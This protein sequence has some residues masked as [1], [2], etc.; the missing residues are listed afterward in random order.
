MSSFFD[1]MPSP[2]LTSSAPFAAD[3]Y[4]PFEATTAGLN[5]SVAEGFLTPGPRRMHE[6][7]ATSAVDNAGWNFQPKPTS[8]P[9]S[10]PVPTTEP[11]PLSRTATR[12][13]GNTAISPG[14]KRRRNFN[15]LGTKIDAWWSAVRSSFS[16]TPEEESHERERRRRTS[17]DTSGGAPL[18]SVA[19][20]TS[21]TFTRPAP[22]SRPSLRNVAS[23]QDLSR[24]ASTQ[25][26]TLTPPQEVSPSR[27]PKATQSPPTLPPHVVP[28]GALAPG[29]RTISTGRLLPP[30]LQHRSSSGSSADSEGGGRSDSRWRNPGL[31]LNLGPS[32]NAM[33]QP[34]SKSPASRLPEGGPGPLATDSST[35]AVSPNDSSRFFSPPLPA[36]SMSA[37]PSERVKSS[38]R[39]WPASTPG[40]TPGH[41]PMWD[42]TPDVVPSSTHF[43][44]RN[45]PAVKNLKDPKEKAGPT[46]SMH[47]VRQQI[48]LR[49][50]SAKENCDKELRKIIHGIS[51]HVE[52]ELHK[53]LAPSP[54]PGM[55]DD[56][57]FNELTAEAE[58]LFGAYGTQG[59]FEMDS[60]S[61]ALADVDDGVE[62]TVHTDS[63]GGT[64]R[65]SSR[66][67]SPLLSPG[68]SS[69]G[70]RRPSS[71]AGTRPRSPRRTSLAPRKR[72]LTSVP[73]PPDFTGYALSE[74]KAKSGSASGAT[75]RSSS[76]SRSPLPPALRN[77][78]NGSRS[79]ALSSHSNLPSS[80]AQ[81]A[82]IVLLQEIITVAT[83]ILDTP[84]TK[85]TAHPGSCAEFIG[86]VQ[87]IGKAWDDNPELACRGWYVQLLLAVAGLSRVLEWWEAERGFWTFDDN[88]DADAEPILFVAKPTAEESPEVRARGDS[89][90]SSVGA[91]LVLPPTS[92]WS[93]LGIDLG[94]AADGGGEEGA[95]G[96]MPSDADKPLE[97][98]TEQHAEALRQ[99]V[100]EIR[101]ST[102]LMELSLDDQLFQFLSSAWEELV[103]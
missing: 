94:L 46:F 63:D 56:G 99:T 5:Y 92:K 67:K 87:Q 25:P 103:G 80:I 57:R 4:N 8:A 83:E 24:P 62:E 45:V 35:S 41:P 31:S 93:P 74:S 27:A 47:T 17:I 78:S 38:N 19:S 16:V 51:T 73:R 26:P 53:D 89:Y 23:A 81:S 44:V 88:D 9:T 22:V 13:S 61:E 12:S 30:K 39:P 54:A 95:M 91:S 6:T 28:A 69:T 77:V 68:T 33:V 102:L 101:S 76:R 52:V 2:V 37:T 100:E 49:L 71:G 60:E 55:T 36:S 7:F 40:L 14:V 59:P 65:P 43:P 79:P 29:A 42:R 82:F 64:S 98:T 84:V 32:F 75:S 66:M 90:S 34:K 48:R 10:V 11:F 15:K 70:T 58:S 3:E 97:E 50:V 18:A 20:R 72:N 85:L 86:R 1:S 96:P 21:S